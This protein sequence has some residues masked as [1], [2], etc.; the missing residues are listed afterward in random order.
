MLLH[1]ARVGLGDAN[2]RTA[3]LHL[4]S[5]YNSAIN[6][7]ANR[8]SP[9]AFPLNFEGHISNRDI[10]PREMLELVFERFFDTHFE[11]DEEGVSIH[12]SQSLDHAHISQIISGISFSAP[13]NYDLSDPE[14]Y[15]SEIA[16]SAVH[17]GAIR[18]MAGELN[19]ILV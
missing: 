13:Q 18:L 8:G 5:L 14:L 15:P 12:Q 19:K 6:A 1:E 11:S 10:Y 3:S 16:V 2:L 9:C 7:A 4:V 17:G